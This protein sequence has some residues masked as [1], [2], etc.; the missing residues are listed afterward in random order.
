MAAAHDEILAQTGFLPVDYH[1]RKKDDG[2]TPST[3]LVVSFNRKTFRIWRLLGTSKPARLI[4]QKKHQ[5]QIH[6]WQLARD[7]APAVRCKTSQTNANAR[8]APIT[9]APNVLSTTEAADRYTSSHKICRHNRQNKNIPCTRRH[10]SRRHGETQ[11]P[12]IA[13]AQKT[14]AMITV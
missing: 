3:V 8:P 11:L 12:S 6:R 7:S 5:N 13:K 9:T 10:A 1:I 14:S 4:R 2:T